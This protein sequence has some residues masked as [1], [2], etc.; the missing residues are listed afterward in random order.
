[1]ETYSEEWAS[2]SVEFEADQR[3]SRDTITQ[4]KQ[5]NAQLKAKM[6]E[7]DKVRL[8]YRETGTHCAPSYKSVGVMTNDGSTDSE[9]EPSHTVYQS[10]NIKYDVVVHEETTPRPAEANNNLIS[11]GRKAPP[12]VEKPPRK[13]REVSSKT[14]SSLGTW[15]NSTNTIHSQ[16]PVPLAR[17]K[18]VANANGQD[19]IGRSTTASR[20]R[21]AHSARSTPT[22]TPRSSPAPS[23]ATGRT[24]RAVS[25]E[26][27]RSTP[28]GRSSSSISSRFPIN[29]RDSSKSSVG[30]MGGGSS[31]GSHGGVNKASSSSS[32]V[33]SGGVTGQHKSQTAGLTD[34]HRSS[35]SLVTRL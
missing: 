29:R 7:R 20:S 33:G 3:H 1:M 23:L 13:S 16:S 4:L 21:L 6:D 35:G 27:G 24:V 8:N 15:N 9:E 22:V 31:G 18:D 25:Q 14:A 11:E 10:P 26:G 32:S 5:D 34:P 17:S 28:V 30:S 12:A 2:K 19:S